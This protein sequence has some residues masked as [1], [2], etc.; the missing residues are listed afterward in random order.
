MPDERAYT[1]SVSISNLPTRSD[2]KTIR[3]LL[4]HVTALPTFPVSQ[5]LFA[6]VQEPTIESKGFTEATQ[7]V[8]RP[9]ITPDHNGQY[10]AS[11]CAIS[12]QYVA[13]SYYLS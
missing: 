4:C 10:G 9:C 8:E 12:F 6:L 7:H 13:C 5:L 1:T 11:L 3:L 2:T